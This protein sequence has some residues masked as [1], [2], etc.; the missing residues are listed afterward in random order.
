MIT[1]NVVDMTNEEDA[2]SVENFYEENFDWKLLCSENISHT[3]GRAWLR[4]PG[5]IV[6]AAFDG[7]EM[8][9][10]VTVKEDMVLYPMMK[11]GDRV[12]ILKALILAAYEANGNYLRAET[13]NELILTTAVDMNI[14]VVRDGNNLE[15]K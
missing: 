1:A 2:L 5:R 12:E 8:V 13:N 9:G 11:D 14:G 6:V 7:K 10:V 15:F 3:P 4:S